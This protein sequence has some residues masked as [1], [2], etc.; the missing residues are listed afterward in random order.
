MPTCLDIAGAEYPDSINGL[1]TVGLDGKS[2]MPLMMEETASI[3]DT[4]FWEHQ[5]GRA[6]RIGEWKMSSL[7][8]KPWELFHITEDYTETRDLSSKYPEKVKEMNAAWEK[9]YSQILNKNN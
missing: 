7:P 6:I 5:G 1:K 4:L 3:H 8:N 2:L 9:L